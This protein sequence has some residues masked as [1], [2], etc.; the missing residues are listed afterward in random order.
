MVE[1]LINAYSCVAI[2]SCS[3]HVFGTNY[4]IQCLW[5][6]KVENLLRLLPEILKATG[7]R[8]VEP[9]YPIK[10]RATAAVLCIL[11]P[12]V[13]LREIKQP[14]LC[15]HGSLGQDRSCWKKFAAQQLLCG[16]Q[17]PSSPFTC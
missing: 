2:K 9:I 11:I 16:V 10:D 1:S 14:S 15:T 12:P 8:V 4:G 6:L 7:H 13:A 3:N 5:N 17:F